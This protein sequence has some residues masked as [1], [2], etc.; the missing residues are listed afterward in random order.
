MKR[1]SPT[2]EREAR[3][4][5][6]TYSAELYS[7]AVRSLGATGP[8]EE[9]VEETFVRAWRTQD[10]LDPEVDTV[11]TSLFAILHEVLV[12]RGHDPTAALATWQ[13]EEAMRKIGPQHREVLVEVHLRR[14]PSAEV[15]TEMG[16]PEAT[17]RGRVYDGLRALREA[18]D[19]VGFDQRLSPVRGESNLR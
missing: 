13:V 19:E 7:F 4:A 14:R 3:E 17:V 18:M 8:A 9:A 11:R 6:S 2:R 15:A 10:P 16:V 1:G 12:E 5:Y